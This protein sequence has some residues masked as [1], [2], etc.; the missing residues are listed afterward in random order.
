MFIVNSVPCSRFH[1]IGLNCL[2]SHTFA[3]TPLIQIELLSVTSTSN[4]LTLKV[5]ASDLMC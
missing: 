2:Y 5:R 4:P 3:P 1:Q